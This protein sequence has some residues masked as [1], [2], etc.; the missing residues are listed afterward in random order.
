MNLTVRATGVEDLATAMLADEPKRCRWSRRRDN[1]VGFDPQH[2]L[3]ASLVSNGGMSRAA[4]RHGQPVTQAHALGRPMIDLDLTP[5]IKV[6]ARVRAPGPA[7][8][9][10]HPSAVYIPARTT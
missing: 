6:H 1:S 3:P 7:H 2:H 4:M 5:S 8:F 10:I 9:F